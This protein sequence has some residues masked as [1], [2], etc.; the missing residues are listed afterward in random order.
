M[1]LPLA[2]EIHL[3]GSWRIGFSFER[4]YVKEQGQE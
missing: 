3:K 1:F 4:D 2:M